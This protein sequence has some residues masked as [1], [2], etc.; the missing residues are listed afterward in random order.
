[1]R[2]TPK[3]SS[4]LKLKKKKKKK[5]KGSETERGLHS[6]V[7]SPKCP[8]QPSLGQADAR[9]PEVSLGLPCGW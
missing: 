2:D 3:S 1:M 5:L 7:H 8:Q 9:S 4:E 6:P